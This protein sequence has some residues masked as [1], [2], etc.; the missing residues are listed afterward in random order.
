M[1][2]VSSLRP[3]ATHYPNHLPHPLSTATQTPSHRV[4][5]YHQLESALPLYVISFSDPHSRILSTL[6][7]CA[8]HTAEG[9][10]D[11]MFHTTIQP[12]VSLQLELG[13]GMGVTR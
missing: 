11:D 7:S 6:A 1:A 13:S 12:P 8:F 2:S 9:R 4:H 10:R 5:F 3:L